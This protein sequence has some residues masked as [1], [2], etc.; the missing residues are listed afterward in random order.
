MPHAA[1]IASTSPLARMAESGRLGELV[2]PSSPARPHLD[3]AARRYARPLQVQICGRPGTGRDTLARALHE[4][5]SVTAIGP[6]ETSAVEVA[7]ADLWIEVLTGP[8]RRADHEHLSGLP[9]D[10]TI[11]V[12]GKS[13]THADP[14]AVAQVC[15][16]QTGVSVYPVSGLLACADL[17][18][19]EFD[20][21]R[22][23]A[24][25]G[26]TMPPMA[27]QFLVGTVLGCPEPPGVGPFL[28]DERSLRADLLRRV[29]RYGI[30]TALALII[31]ESRGA[32]DVRSLNVELRRHSGIGRLFAPI[33]ERVETVRFWRLVEL[34]ARLEIIAAAG[35]DRDAVEH[36]LQNEADR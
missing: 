22:R 10:R 16:A 24:A 12:L 28:G 1:T 31:S 14:E 23:L 4:R 27:G 32:V 25:A 34:R 9:P 35:V 17:G 15:A 2:A 18:A 20:Y 5:L 19:D 29:D 36:L 21:L 13:D 30:E 3:D 6:G 26:E 8:P 11:V 7:D 33:S